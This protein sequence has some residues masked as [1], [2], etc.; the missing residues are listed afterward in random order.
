MQNNA[1]LIEETNIAMTSAIGRPRTVLDVGCGLGLNGAVAVSAGASVGGVEGDA[2]RAENARRLLGEVIAID[3]REVDRVSSELGERKFDLILFADL[4][5]QS[6]APV[7]LLHG[8]LRHLE[9]E[10]RVMV[11]LRNRTAWNVLL[12]MQSP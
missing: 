9:P 1:P 12:K 6:D 2:P 5:E 10:G 3:P 7:D 8:Y 4:L 11:A